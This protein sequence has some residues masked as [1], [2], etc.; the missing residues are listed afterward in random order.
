[1]TLRFRE[2]VRLDP[3]AV[4]AWTMIVRVRAAIGDRGGARATLDEALEANPSNEFLQSLSE[5]FD[6]AEKQ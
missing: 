2:V 6:A 1:M 4:E 5:E 3:Q